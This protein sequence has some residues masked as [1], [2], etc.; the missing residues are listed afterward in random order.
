MKEKTIIYTI[1][2]DSELDIYFFEKRL[3]EENFTARRVSVEDLSKSPI[4]KPAFAGVVIFNQFE[5]LKIY[6]AAI[7]MRDYLA[8]SLGNASHLIACGNNLISDDEIELR[9]MPFYKV[10][11]PENRQSESITERILAALFG[12]FNENFI[13]DEDMYLEC[14]VLHEQD[15]KTIKFIGATQTMRKIFDDIKWMCNEKE[16]VL[17]RGETG[18][19]KELVGAALNSLNPKNKGR[20]YQAINITEI[21][22]EL[23][24]AIMYGSIK[25]I[26]TG[27]AD[28]AGLLARKNLEIPLLGTLLIDEIGDASKSIQ[29]KMLRLL[30]NRRYRTLG[31]LKDTGLD[32]NLRFIFATNRPIEKMAFE[33]EFREDFYQRLKEGDEI[34]LPLLSE[35]KA[36]FEILAKEFFSKWDEEQSEQTSGKLKLMQKDFDAI[37]NVCSRHKFRGNVRGF[38]SHLRRCFRHST[39]KESVFDINFLEKQLDIE[40]KQIE[41]QHSKSSNNRVMTINGANFQLEAQQ[42]NNIDSPVLAPQLPFVSF[43][44]RKESMKEF[45]EKARCEYLQKVYLMTNRDVKKTSKLAGISEKTFYK[46]KKQ[47]GIT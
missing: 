18:T 32:P 47:C 21:S 6:S 24:E 10:I 42:S 16:T 14:E 26:Y 35:R 8:D 4:G 1:I 2:N 27:A 9:K 15:T 19:G 12:G 33:G 17:I 22:D 44:P 5:A 37:V 46:Y 13:L 30:E 29:T 41:N 23:F 34:Q 43:D 38:R 31:K 3:K 40:K 36:D 28:R 45:I 7:K 39:R 25:G 11:Q 20:E